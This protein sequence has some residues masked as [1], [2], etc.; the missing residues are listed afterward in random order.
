MFKSNTS[1][2]DRHVA[3]LC[4]TFQ[5]ILHKSLIRAPSGYSKDFRL[6]HDLV[7]LGKKGS[8]IALN[9]PAEL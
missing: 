2:M 7:K 3:H 9:T 4:P 1:I 6:T 5:T 8:S